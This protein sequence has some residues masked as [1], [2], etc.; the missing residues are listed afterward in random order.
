MLFFL[1]QFLGGQRSHKAIQER[2]INGGS[3][4]KEPAHED[5]LEPLERG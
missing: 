2:G 5:I 3:L 1:M 4:P